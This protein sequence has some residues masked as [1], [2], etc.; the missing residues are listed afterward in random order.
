MFHLWMI[1]SGLI[2]FL[3]LAIYYR[4]HKIK[5]VKVLQSEGISHIKNLRSVLCLLQK[6][7]GFSSTYIKGQP[8]VETQID[9]IQTELNRILADVLRT[10][11]NIMSNALWVS[12]NEHW[13]RLSHNYKHH[14]V[15][16]NV[17]QH[18]T[19]IQ[20]LLYLIDDVAISHGLARLKLSN[21]DNIRLL[22][23][24][25]LSAIESM[26]QARAMGAVILAEGTCSIM[27]RNRMMYLHEKIIETTNIAWRGI[28]VTDEQKRQVNRLIACIKIE[29]INASQTQSMSLASSEYFELC[30]A[31]IDSY[32]QRFD[33]S[34]A[35]L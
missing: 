11:S 24:E 12:V 9:A 21:I 6:H 7:R 31:V 28:T 2:S 29:I 26:G 33:D 19:M 18:N 30:S 13:Q 32:Y 17:L 23:R 3:L 35:Q 27:S 20:N 34:I 10:N 15:E 4:Y 1:L 14:S 5:D 22:W 25:W 16:N 8:D